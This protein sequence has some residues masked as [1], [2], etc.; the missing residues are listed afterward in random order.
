MDDVEFTSGST[1]WLLADG[2]GVGDRLELSL[3]DNEATQASQLSQVLREAVEELARTIRSWQGAEVFF[4]AGDEVLARVPRDSVEERLLED[5]RASF[6]NQTGCSLSVGVGPDPRSATMALRRAK[7][8]G[9]DRV[10][11]EGAR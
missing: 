11:F 1:L 6:K 4:A 7:L 2:D 8:L 5:A 10:S 3:L 9:K